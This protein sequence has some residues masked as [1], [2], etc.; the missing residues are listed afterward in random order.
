[1]KEGITKIN[2][3]HSWFFKINDI[4]KLLARLIKKKGRRAK[5]V[6]L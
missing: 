6:K 1:M 4:D 3:T 5:S 2:N